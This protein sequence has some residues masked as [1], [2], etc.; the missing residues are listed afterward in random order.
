MHFIVDFLRIKS[1]NTLK[2]LVEWI[3]NPI[4]IELV[5]FVLLFVS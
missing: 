1:D 3:K 4:R 2:K 5:Q